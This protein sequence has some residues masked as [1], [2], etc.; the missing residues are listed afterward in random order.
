MLKK[1][2]V[3]GDATMAFSAGTWAELER[4]LAGMK[5]RIARDAVRSES[6]TAFY[7]AGR[8][9]R[10]AVLGPRDQD[11]PSGALL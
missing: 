11:R 5:L 9:G 1:M 8:N 3:I 2:V 4:T 10:R 6:L 7:I